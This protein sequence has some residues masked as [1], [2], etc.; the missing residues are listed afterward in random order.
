MGLGKFKAER[1]GNDFGVSY[2]LLCADTS[3]AT[4]TS[5]SIGKI[6]GLAAYL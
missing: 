5:L 1:S 2:T 3:G 6:L 4:R